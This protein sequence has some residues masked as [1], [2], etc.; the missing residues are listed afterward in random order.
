MRKE[1]KHLYQ[2]AIDSLTLSI[3]LFNRPNDCG[4][5][6]GVLIFMNHSFEMLLK[7]SIIHKGGKIKEKGAKETIGF[8]ACVRKGFSDNTIK[9]LSDTDVLTLQTINGL[10]DAA[11]HYT[12]EMSE[13]YLYFQAQAGLTLFRD[14][15]KKV[16]NIDLKT[17]LPVRVLPLST[18]PPMDI[19]AFFSTEVQE[20]K[21]LLA[22]KSRK[23]LEATEKLRALAIME[24]AIQGNESQPS[25]TELKALA[26][27]LSKATN[28]GQLFPSVSTLSFTQ[29]GYGPSLDLRITKSEGVPVTVV[30]EGTPGAGVVAIKRVNEL[31][32]YNLGRDQLAKKLGLTGPKTTAAVKHFGIKDDP[33]C[34]KHL[35]VGNVP[36]DRYSQ[37]AIEKIKEGLKTKTIEEIWNER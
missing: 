3:E 8:G 28:W 33:E 1:A 34:F 29:N 17:Q 21:K 36:F 7:A 13:Q 2:K 22:P 23:K 15:A 32:F 24:N 12:L 25:D 35:K 30:P 6:H 4:R 5:I 31:D 19:Q 37:K 11:Q 16:F 27:R 10:R 26:K 9:F 20:I 14:I 18:T